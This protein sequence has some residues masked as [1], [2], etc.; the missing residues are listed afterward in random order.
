MP[1]NFLLKKKVEKLR[2]SVPQWRVGLGPNHSPHSPGN[3]KP[4]EL[5]SNSLGSR[6]AEESSTFGGGGGTPGWLYIS[7]TSPWESPGRRD[8]TWPAPHSTSSSP[9]VMTRKRS[10]SE[11]ADPYAG[12]L[13]KH[14]GQKNV[15]ENK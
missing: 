10:W 13:L 14:G 11:V 15:I 5:F 1:V 6:N 8:W 12:G 2:F 9:S 4:V 7:S 3:L